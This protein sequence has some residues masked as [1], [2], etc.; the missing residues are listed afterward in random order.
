MDD[1]GG[2]FKSLRLFPHSYFGIILFRVSGSN[3]TMMLLSIRSSMSW[4]K[5]IL[6]MVGLEKNSFRYFAAS[7]SVA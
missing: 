1:N 7:I 5:A 4:L 6:A 3:V 2:F